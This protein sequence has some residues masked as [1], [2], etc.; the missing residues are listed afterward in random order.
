M[1]LFLLQSVVPNNARFREPVKSGDLTMND[2]PM[3]VV[4]QTS[5]VGIS[6]SSD[7]DE[8]TVLENIKKARRTLYSLMPAIHLYLFIMQHPLA[9][10]LC[11]NICAS[12]QLKTFLKE[13]SAEINDNRVKI[14]KS[15]ERQVKQ[16]KNSVSFALWH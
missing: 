15:G 7:S 12:S 2:R 16:V 13:C 11:R 9:R 14:L 6:R 1:E 3:S 8:T 4:E 5:H 10:I